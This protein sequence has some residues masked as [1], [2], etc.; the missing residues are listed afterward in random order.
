MGAH[1]DQSRKAF[2]PRPTLVRARGRGHARNGQ[3]QSSCLLGT[4]ALAVG[5]V[6]GQTPDAASTAAAESIAWGLDQTDLWSPACGLSRPGAW[7]AMRAIV[8][9][10]NPATVMLAFRSCSSGR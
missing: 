4:L 3:M 10:T 2:S 7:E 5:Q 6:G 8:E 9:Q 1:G